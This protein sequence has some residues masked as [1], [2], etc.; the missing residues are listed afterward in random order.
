MP[1]IMGTAGHIDHRQDDLIKALTSDCN[2]LARSGSAESPVELGFASLDLTPQVQL[3]IITFRATS[4][5]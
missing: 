4:G 5:S 2:R 3:G 1:V